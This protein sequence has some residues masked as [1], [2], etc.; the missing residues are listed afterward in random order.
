MDADDTQPMAKHELDAMVEKAR[1]VATPARTPS[2]KALPPVS[3]TSAPDAPAFPDV[4]SGYI[5]RRQQF[6][7]RKGAPIDNE[8]P[9]FADQRAK[10]KKLK[11][12]K[13]AKAKKAKANKASQV[14]NKA[15]RSRSVLK[16]SSSRRRLEAEQAMAAGAEYE[17]LEAAA[18]AAK[19]SCK[20]KAKAKAKAKASAKA[21]AKASG[22]ATPA[23]VKGKA[24]AKAKAKAAKA[25]AEA[26]A[27]E[28][29]SSAATKKRGCKKIVDDAPEA[30]SSKPVK[31]ARRS[32]ASA[33][34]E[35][36][37]EPSLEVAGSGRREADPRL[38][39]EAPLRTGEEVKAA[40][41]ELWTDCHAKGPKHLKDGPNVI[42]QFPTTA[43]VRLVP[44]WH[45]HHMGVKVMKTQDDGISKLKQPHYFS[46]QGPCWCGLVFCAT[47]LAPRIVNTVCCFQA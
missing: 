29:A 17:E 3:G 18:T 44:Y 2:S 22:K 24:K 31:R 21:A 40:L 7:V 39:F 25:P 45:K 14:K 26:K 11:Q 5:T 36:V 30:S 33:A 43:P 47:Q 42:C 41:W 35:A 37:H 9:D 46:M 23:P 28:D 27:S 12:K 13:N 1:A 10:A 32:K 15:S 8:D 20:P 38:E 19:K 6:A 34:A 4:P 16:A